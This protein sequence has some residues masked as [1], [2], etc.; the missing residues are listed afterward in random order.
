M[1]LTETA[2]WFTR[3]GPPSKCTVHF[4]SIQRKKCPRKGEIKFLKYNLPDTRHQLSTMV[5][6]LNCYL[7]TRNRQIPTLQLLFL[8]YDCCC[9]PWKICLLIA[10]SYNSVI[11]CFVS[12][13]ALF[14]LKNARTHYLI[15]KTYFSPSIS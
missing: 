7:D 11:R 13:S 8:L 2:A 6:I 12:K 3:L 1:S 10:G 9:L 14:P 15:W 4:I 5:T